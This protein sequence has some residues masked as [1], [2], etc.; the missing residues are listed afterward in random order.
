MAENRPATASGGAESGVY[1]TPNR[2]KLV[3]LT[4]WCSV[5]DCEPGSEQGEAARSGTL[6]T[7]HCSAMGAN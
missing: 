2:R 4:K 6:A 7:A 1:A 3:R 5:A